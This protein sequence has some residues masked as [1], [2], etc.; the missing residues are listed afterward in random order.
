M[1]FFND[2]RPD[3]LNDLRKFRMARISPLPAPAVMF[4]VT[5]ISALPVAAG[6]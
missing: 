6:G 5:R 1:T 4:P 3:T 2:I